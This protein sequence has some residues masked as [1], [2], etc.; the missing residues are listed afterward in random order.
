LELVHSIT[1]S[2]CAG[3]AVKKLSY[4]IEEWDDKE[5]HVVDVLARTEQSLAET[6]FRE[7]A[8][9]H[10]NSRILL[11]HETTVVK[12]HVPQTN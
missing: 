11:I 2:S 7:A 8:K 3:K 4:T 6:A 5:L 1:L 9:Q 10:P 12:R